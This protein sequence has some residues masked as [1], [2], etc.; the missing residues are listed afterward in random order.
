MGSDWFSAP[1][2]SHI[3]FLSRL[4]SVWTLNL[5][6]ASRKDRIISHPLSSPLFLLLIPQVLSRTA[7][8]SDKYLG[9]DLR[10]FQNL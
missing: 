7:G 6:Y 3:W 4:F 9:P 1:I 2:D 5:C 10:G 8:C